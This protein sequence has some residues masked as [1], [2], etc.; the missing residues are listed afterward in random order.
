M[1]AN[2]SDVG[3]SRSPLPRLNRSNRLGEGGFA[4]IF[5][6]PNHLDRYIKRF[7][8]PLV[9]TAIDRLDRLLAVEQW[10]RPS[11]RSILASRFA[12]PIE[13]FGDSNSVTG[14]SMHRAPEECWFELTLRRTSTKLLDLT[15][16]TNA[17]YWQAPFIRSAQPQLL[18]SQRR[19]LAIDIIESVLTLHR[20]HLVYGDISSK[21][22]CARLGVTPSVF[23]VDADSIGLPVEVE[24]NLQMTPDW[25]VSRSFTPNQ[26]DC[27]LTAVLVWRL[28]SQQAGSYPSV[29]DS[30]VLD[31]AGAIDIAPGIFDAYST[32]DTQALLGVANQLREL[33]D[34]QAARTA[35]SRAQG[36]RF[37][38]LVAQESKGRPE[39]DLIHESVKADAQIALEAAIEV[40]T[41]AE[42]RRLTRR[43]LLTSSWFELDVHPD[44]ASQ[45][46]NDQRHLRE[47]MYDA[48]FE[49]IA[50]H[51]AEQGL[52][53]LEADPWLERA[54][55]HALAKVGA[56][57]VQTSTGPGKATLSWS[58]PAAS[59]ANSAIVIPSTGSRTRRLK[60]ILIPRDPG[61]VTGSVEILS[62][63]AVSGRARV[64]FSVRSGS[65]SESGDRRQF[66]GSQSS[67]TDFTITE[68]TR[69]R[70]Y[71][72]HIALLPQDRER[73]AGVVVIDPVQAATDLAEHRKQ[74]RVR[75]W[76]RA[77]ICLAAAAI[78]LGVAWTGWARFAH[79]LIPPGERE[80]VFASD[81][82]G[83]WDIY[84]RRPNGNVEALTVNSHHDRNPVWHPNGEFI[85]FESN[86]DGDWELLRMNTD[87]TDVRSYTFNQTAEI[88]PAWKG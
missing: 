44:A 63:T 30:T 49:V 35:V 20:N 39:P 64:V 2:Q 43:A 84:V 60:P 67:H 56:P 52:G 13:S 86:Y 47:L 15:Y 77:A 78:L 87:G 25:V 66:A 75:R 21:N 83:D 61:E 31:S 74:V 1:I 81:R 62:Q 55:K 12:W 82:D 69:T 3:G 16:L 4:E 79:Y 19:E 8:A 26:R 71:R 24:S 37:A 6:D 48:E 88:D 51:L 17:A 70:E 5:Q 58:W 29:G 36:T 54:I 76:K 28:L 32:G 11:D 42:H 34:Y 50:A 85:A 18:V 33:R 73:E 80:L 59:F 27:A 57:S 7:K 23:I 41:T 72:D 68:P 22:F 53:S 46:P 38:R 40:A 65:K 14:F 45:R 10:A 9:G